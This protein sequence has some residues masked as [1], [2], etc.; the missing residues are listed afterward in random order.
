MTCFVRR[1]L[2]LLL[3]CA[4]LRAQVPD[5]QMF[6]IQSLGTVSAKSFAHKMPNAARKELEKGLKALHTGR[7]D[8]ALAHLTQAARL[9]PASV[10]VQ[11]DLGVAYA[12]TGSLDR[13]LDRFDQALG[14][15]PNRQALYEDKANILMLLARFEEAE[16]VAR[17]ALRRA[18]YSANA[19]YTLAMSLVRR[20]LVTPEAVT[21]LKLA[22]AKDPRAGPAL[23][24]AQNHV[25]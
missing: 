23:E 20:G 3:A 7:N 14:L 6:D 18:P 24:W 19:N 22:A 16:P 25:K 8:Q 13:A 1:I 9:D 4:A 2:T 11:A 5:T 12:A 10:E 17:E 21:C 15:D